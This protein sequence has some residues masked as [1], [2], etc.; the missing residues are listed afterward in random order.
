MRQAMDQRTTDVRPAESVPRATDDRRPATQSDR[1]LRLALRAGAA[2][3]LLLLI[4]GFYA[5]G[6]WVW[7][8][9]GPTGHI[10]NF[11]ISLWFVGLVLAPTLASR[12]PLARTAAIQVY[13]LAVIAIVLSTFR[14]GAH[15]AAEIGL[16]PRIAEII[17]STLRG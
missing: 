17:V 15:S 1:G 16:L 5:P 7:G 8:L 13:L 3:W 9:P 12:E 11:M 2:I 4:V 6:N 14:G 10:Y